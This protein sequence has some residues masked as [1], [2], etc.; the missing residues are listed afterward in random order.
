[1]ENTHMQSIENINFQTLQLLEFEKSTFCQ[2][3]FFGEI[4][5]LKFCTYCQLL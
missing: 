5:L 3:E 2:F 4:I 1:M